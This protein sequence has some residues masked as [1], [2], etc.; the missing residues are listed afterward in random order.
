MN[1]LEH[2]LQLVF[3]DG[4]GSPVDTPLPSKYFFARF[5]ELIR[6]DMTNFICQWKFFLRLLD[7]LERSFQSTLISLFWEDPVAKNEPDE[8]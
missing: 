4:D 6:D 7:G 2:T 5:A 1:Y 8:E 3:C